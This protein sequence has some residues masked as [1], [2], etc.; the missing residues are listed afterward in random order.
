MFF[1][2][3]SV[4][5]LE[6]DG[7]K[8]AYPFLLSIASGLLFSAGWPA[9]GFPLLLMT[10]FVPLFF[11]EKK[12]NETGGFLNPV[13][14][15]I[16]SY[17]AFFIWN[18]LTT[19][20]IY[21]SSPEGAVM[22]VVF[23][24]LFMSWVYFLAFLT[25]KKLGE[26][27]GAWALPIYWL[28]FE[29]LHMNWDLSWPWLTLGN[30]FAAFPEWVQWYEYTGTGG[31][32]IWILIVNILLFQVIQKFTWQKTIRA[33]LLILLPIILSLGLYFRYH[34]SGKPLTVAVIQPNVDPW[35]E[36][37]DNNSQEQQFLR[38]I[39][40][41][42]QVADSST[43]YI[44]F[45][46]TALPFGFW[47]FQKDSLPEFLSFR[48]FLTDNLPK[49]KMVL[50]VSYLEMFTPNH[51]SEIPVSAMRY[52]DSEKY[53]EDYNSVVQVDTSAFIP[54]YHKSKLVPGPEAFPF[55]RYLMPFQQKLFG[56][57]GGMIGNLGRQKERTVFTAPEDKTM[58]VGPIICYESIYGEFVTEYVRRGAK[59]LFIVTNDGWWGDTPG[60]RQHFQYARL[61]AIETRRSIARSANTGISGFINQRGDVVANTP[62]WQEN[63]LQA[64]L[65]ANE[66][67]TFYV[68]NG[69]YIGRTA[70]FTAF[71]MLLYAFVKGFLQK[72]RIPQ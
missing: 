65:N 41:T 46:E 51:P 64:T 11:A 44:V 49:A 61:R 47:N 7:V 63:A 37:F 3:Q 42:E 68:E 5:S 71:F 56:N 31:G 29:Y 38:L 54:I 30:G 1:P 16:T 18:L 28:G 24:S 36:K 58:G 33:F 57:L 21:N 34:E 9:S 69:D 17:L 50:G 35:N 55:A 27:A 13:K 22:A 14:V 48:K 8:R 60:Y 25:K 40:L 52:G 53:Y 4:P 43:D 67:I 62:Y 59:L 6:I 70:V 19:W 23:N 72:K 66:R 12:I 20:W 2:L 10:A 26:K 45:P 15:W 32:S 39:S